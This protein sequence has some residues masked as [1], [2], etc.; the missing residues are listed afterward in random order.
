M[1]IDWYLVGMGSIVIVYLI[2]LSVMGY[3]EFTESSAEKAAAI[4]A[5]AIRQPVVCKEEGPL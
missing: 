2:F 1:K 5:E 4:I 3:K